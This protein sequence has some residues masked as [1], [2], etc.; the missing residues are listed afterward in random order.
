MKMP[1]IRK[2]TRKNRSSK[3]S[4]RIPKP[5]SIPPYLDA[6]VALYQILPGK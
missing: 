3:I 4:N 2:N 1:M 6:S 5:I